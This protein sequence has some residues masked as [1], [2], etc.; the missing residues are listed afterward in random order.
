MLLCETCICRSSNYVVVIL[1]DCARG[2]RVRIVFP[3][4]VFLAREVEDRGEAAR[5]ACITT[6]VQKHYLVR[7]Y[8]SN[9]CTLI[10]YHNEDAYV[11]VRTVSHD[12]VGD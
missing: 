3:E 2:N 12:D 8:T 10:W 6:A 9:V 11:R 4:F 5:S 1:I 7:V